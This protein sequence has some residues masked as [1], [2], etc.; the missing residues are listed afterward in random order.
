M[1]YE[2]N[3]WWNRS[4]MTWK[5]HPTPQN[6]DKMTYQPLCSPVISPSSPRL[7]APAVRV[8]GMFIHHTNHCW[9][10]EKTLVKHSR[11][12]RV[13][14]Y[15]WKWSIFSY[16]LTLKTKKR[17]DIELLH[18]A[19]QTANWQAYPRKRWLQTKWTQRQ[20]SVTSQWN[21]TNSSLW[22]VRCKSSSEPWTKQKRKWKQTNKSHSQN[23]NKITENLP[24]PQD[25]K[26]KKRRK[27]ASSRD[28]MNE[29]NKSCA[30]NE[31]IRQNTD[32]SVH[33]ET[34]NSRVPSHLL[35][36]ISWEG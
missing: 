14:H 18:S 17:M 30:K 6:V 31:E 16:K 15:W 3:T 27:K 13:S 32:T 28:T 33:K 4:S 29:I 12:K 1:G 11:K 22:R 24:P 34:A 20:N 5:K 36:L 26:K 8:G 19:A 7:H 23:K 35:P 2:H 10:K 21:K 9:N 25:K